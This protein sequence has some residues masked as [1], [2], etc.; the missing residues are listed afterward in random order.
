[1]SA[2]GP[3]G[4]DRSPSTRMPALLWTVLERPSISRP[5]LTSTSAGG[6]ACGG[7]GA[8]AG[9]AWDRHGTR[10]ATARDSVSSDGRP[11]M[12]SPVKGAENVRP[13]QRFSNAA[14]GSGVTFT[15]DGN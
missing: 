5:A 13:S 10:G 2:S 7:G 15:G 12:W 14:H 4:L 6:G 9:G 11:R 8:G 1:T 3:I